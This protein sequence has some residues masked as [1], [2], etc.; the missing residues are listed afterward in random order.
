MRSREFEDERY[1]SNPTDRCYFCKTN[2]YDAIEEIAGAGF[3]GAGA[4]VPSGANM[5]DLGEYRPGPAAEHAVRHPYIEAGISKTDIRAIARGLGVDFAN[6]VL[7]AV[8]PACG[9]S[10]PPSVR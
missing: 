10:V 4:V 2:L 1:L 7:T 9:R 3:A 5:D 6:D 8:T